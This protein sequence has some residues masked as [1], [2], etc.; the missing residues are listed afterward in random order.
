MATVI[1]KRVKRIPGLRPGKIPTDRP[2]A[3]A[4]M[5]GGMV[6]DIDPADIKDNQASLLVNARVRRDKTTRR[7]GKSSFLPTK[8]NSNPVIRMY[9]FKLGDFTFYRVRFTASDIYYTD[10]AAWTQLT[11]TFGGKPTGIATVLGTL[12]AANGIDRLQKLDLDANTI[13]DLGSIAPLAKYVTGFSERVVGAN[14]GDSESASET[15]AW[16]GNRNLS[17]FDA[18]VDISSGNKRLDTSPRTVVDPIRGVFGFSSV[19]IIPRERSIWLATQQPTA[20]DPFNTFRAVPGVGTDL[21]SSIAIGRE[22]IMFLDARTRD[23]VVY[24]PGQ[25]LQSIG[26]PIRDSIL[27]NVTDPGALSSAY[28]EN[29]DEFYI[30]ITESATVK[31]WVVNLRTTS[32]QYDEVPNLTS[33]DSITLFSSYTSFDDATGTFDA[34]SGTLDA[35]SVTPIHIPTLAYG[36]SDGL[37]L[38]E[39]STVQQDN[40]VNYTFELRS[41]EFKN[42]KDDAVITRILIEY[43]ATVSGSI[44]LSYSKDGG[45]TW[46]VAKTVTT[47]TGRV[48]RI[49]FKKQIRTERLMWRVTATDGQ[50][51]I[52][53]YEV[54]ISAG[55]ESKGT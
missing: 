24:S 27:A 16:S 17:E 47:S 39:D 45:T 50:F 9:D 40:T 14:T 52:L 55:G 49:K 12:V 54:D 3:I 1:G 35:A 11:G 29:E 22:K 43:Q 34:A 36:Y 37:L 31:V 53:G 2:L 20:S 8:P 30:T 28:L 19:M 32:R 44:I 15:I 51:D 21:P 10:G 33:L 7:F 46:K 6:A 18:L 42:V 25:P 13:A 41:K 4:V 26:S 48:R 5:N 38:K 23:V